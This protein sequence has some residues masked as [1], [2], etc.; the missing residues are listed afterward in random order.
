MTNLDKSETVR[1]KLY[2]RDHHTVCLKM[3]LRSVLFVCDV[4][5]YGCRLNY[6]LRDAGIFTGGN[7]NSIWKVDGHGNECEQQREWEREC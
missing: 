6:E 2:F 7:G 5:D 4:F 3:V 1:C